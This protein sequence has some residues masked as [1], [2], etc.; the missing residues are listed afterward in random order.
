MRLGRLIRLSLALLLFSLTIPIAV[1]LIP[2]LFLGFVYGV[3]NIYSLVF[4]N[5][6]LILIVVLTAVVAALAAGLTIL[7]FFISLI[8]PRLVLSGCIRATEAHR[9]EEAGFRP[10]Y[11]QVIQAT[12]AG[13]FDL[14]SVSSRPLI[15]AIVAFKTRI[16]VINPQ[17]LQI[18]TPAE[19]EAVLLH[20]RG[21]VECGLNG[22]YL[23]ARQIDGARRMMRREIS[24]D[25]KPSLFG[26]VID[27]ATWVIPPPAGRDLIRVGLRLIALP[28]PAI[29]NALCASTVVL[30]APEFHKAE[31]S[32]DTFVVKAGKA[33]DLARALLTLELFYLLVNDL[34]TS[35]DFPE[36]AD[37]LSLVREF[38]RAEFEEQDLG[39]HKDHTERILMRLRRWS[40]THPSTTSRLR[41][42]GFPPEELLATT[43]I[44]T[45]I[46][47]LENRLASWVEP[48]KAE[49][50][51]EGAMAL[52][53]LQVCETDEFDV[54]LEGLKRLHHNKEFNVA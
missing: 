49:G 13:Y 22:A 29:V 35:K 12:T 1:A 50:E 8:T 48:Q 40:V 7:R 18:F 33:S 42:L 14:I 54:V 24:F 3:V 23:A 45:M 52:G 2:L 9:L 43:E 41:H 28:V 27:V 20:E 11:L 4:T 51:S 6:A 38:E 47:N 31:F 39:E 25:A 16:L 34:A 5:E 36:S 46:S 44:S 17:L 37:W 32:A 53:I 19:V 10:E 26:Q 15:G 21:H 30:L